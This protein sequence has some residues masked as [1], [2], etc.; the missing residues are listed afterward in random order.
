M[1]SQDAAEHVLQHVLF[2]D[3]VTRR[4]R[5]VWSLM[6]IGLVSYFSL[7][8]LV[9]YSPEVL[10]M[11]AEVGAATTIG[12]VLAVAILILGWIITWIYVHRANS[13]FDLLSAQLIEEVK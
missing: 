7:I 5:L 3:L 2:K 12:V 9:A 1:N 11:P 13:T 8:A 6:A 4:A 10:R